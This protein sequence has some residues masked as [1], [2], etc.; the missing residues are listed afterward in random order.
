MEAEPVSPSKRTMLGPVRRPCMLHVAMW[1]NP[2]I[3]L[4]FFIL[5][6]CMLVK[7][8]ITFCTFPWSKE[9]Q[10]PFVLSNVNQSSSQ[11]L[12]NLF[13][14]FLPSI[15]QNRKETSGLR[16]TSTG[17]TDHIQNVPKKNFLAFATSSVEATDEVLKLDPYCRRSFVFW[18]PTT[19][20]RS[21]ARR[22]TRGSKKKNG[23]FKKVSTCHEFGSFCFHFFPQIHMD[24]FFWKGLNNKNTWDAFFWNR[25]G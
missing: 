12:W 3:H 21:H 11:K 6:V 18:I 9:R 2:E 25:K 10:V 19:M 7:S 17:P 4:N 8:R 13:P 24:V 20:G 15:S 22:K 23:T 16:P 1:C 14:P 5:R